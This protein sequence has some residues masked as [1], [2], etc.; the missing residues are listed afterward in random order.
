MSGLNDE[1]IKNHAELLQLMD[2]VKNISEYPICIEEEYSL[3]D[4]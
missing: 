2:E 4:I 1:I 3:S